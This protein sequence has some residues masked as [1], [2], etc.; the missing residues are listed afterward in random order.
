VI[1]IG[2]RKQKIIG[3]ARPERQPDQF[4]AV[5]HHRIVDKIH[6]EGR[7]RLGDR[8]Q[9]EIGEYGNIVVVD[10]EVLVKPVQ[11]HADTLH[12][13][14]F[15]IVHILFAENDGL[16]LLRI[17]AVIVIGIGLFEINR[18]RAGVLPFWWYRCSRR[19]NDRA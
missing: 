5:D 4:L 11:V 13:D 15:P 16:G 8:A 18:E 12:I 19:G 9:K 3:V 10:V 17:F 7:R 6:V 1:H 2:P 14:Q